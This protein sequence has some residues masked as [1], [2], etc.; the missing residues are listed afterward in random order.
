[1]ALAAGVLVETV[2]PSLGGQLVGHLPNPPLVTHVTQSDQLLRR[3]NSQL[4]QQLFKV[5]VTTV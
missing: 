1:M 2:G 5:G 4:F 3:K